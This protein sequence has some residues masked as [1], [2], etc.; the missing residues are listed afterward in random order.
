MHWN[1]VCLPENVNSV[2]RKSPSYL[3]SGEYWEGWGATS[4]RHQEKANTSDL[5]TL[6]TQL[7][8]PQ[9]LFTFNHQIIPNYVIFTQLNF[10]LFT[11]STVLK[12][13]SGHNEQ[14]KDEWSK[15][16]TAFTDLKMWS[17]HNEQRKD[18]W[19]KVTDIYKKKTC[20]QKLPNEG[21]PLSPPLSCQLD[22]SQYTMK[23]M[24]LK[25][26]LATRCTTSSPA[27]YTDNANFPSRWFYRTISWSTKIWF[28][29]YI[30]SDCV[31]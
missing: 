5:P 18:V 24:R 1:R 30:K 16:F 29:I 7:L 15:V 22:L 4:V 8:L 27:P 13:R 2:E 25:L 6:S 14:R 31:H 21:I 17:G 3:E 9:G 10:V 12:I 19:S 23:C 26:L 20:T 28:A 11:A